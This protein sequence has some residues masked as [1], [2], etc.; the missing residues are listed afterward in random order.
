MGHPNIFE[1]QAKVKQLLDENLLT[2]AI[3]KK[4][5]SVE[6]NCFKSAIHADIIHFRTFG[7]TETIF[8]NKRTGR[9]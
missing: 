5:L 2:H 8:Q 7:T 1:R 6:L 9:R 3:I 4:S